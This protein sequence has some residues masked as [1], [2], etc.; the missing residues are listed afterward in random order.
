MRPRTRTLPPI[1]RCDGPCGEALPAT[2]LV[3]TGRYALCKSDIKGVREVDAW[4]RRQELDDPVFGKSS[5]QAM[6][7]IVREE[8]EWTE[9][10]RALRAY[11]GMD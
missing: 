5:R 11:M 6:A 3:L 7:E 8:G 9:S 10:G 4:W 2:M 1:I